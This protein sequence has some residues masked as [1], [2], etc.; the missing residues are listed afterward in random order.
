MRTTILG[1]HGKTKTTKPQSPKLSQQHAADYGNQ[2]R[3][4][5]GAQREKP[6]AAEERNLKI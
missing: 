1:Y 3:Q 6:T 5:M 4:K 2:A